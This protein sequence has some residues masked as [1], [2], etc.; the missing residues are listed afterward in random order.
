MKV[1]SAKA[2]GRRLQYEVRDLL[3]KTAK[4]LEP[5]DIRS[6]PMGSPGE[7]LLLS[8]AARKKFPFN[9][10]CKNVEKLNIWAAIAQAREQGKHTP[11]VAFS[12]NGEQTYVALPIEKFM[13]ILSGSWNNCSCGVL[14]D[15][16]KD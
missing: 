1:S 8:P 10:E 3:L 2:K 15:T 5:D 12:R 4:D 14:P 7:D 16:K 13:E 6:T 9:I 11:M